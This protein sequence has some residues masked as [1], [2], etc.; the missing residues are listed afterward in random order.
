MNPATHNQLMT[1]EEVEAELKR[2]QEKEQS[3]T[4]GN[5]S[6]QNQMNDLRELMKIVNN[7]YDSDAS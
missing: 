5:S 2:L 7:R 6:L 1:D 4:M 3:L